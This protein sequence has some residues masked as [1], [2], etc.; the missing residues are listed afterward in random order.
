M[1]GSEPLILFLWASRMLVS[2]ESWEWLLSPRGSP[3]VSGS[4]RRGSSRSRR[5]PQGLPGRGE[6]GVQGPHLCERPS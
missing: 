4:E 3:V 6:V 2:W 1:E 5:K